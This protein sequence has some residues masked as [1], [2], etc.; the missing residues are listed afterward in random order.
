MEQW[1]EYIAKVFQRFL[2]NQL[3]KIITAIKNYELIALLV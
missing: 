2:L 3:S 1:F